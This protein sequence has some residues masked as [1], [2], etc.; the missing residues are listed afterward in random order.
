MLENFMKQLTKDLEIEESLDTGVP[1]VYMFPVDENIGIDISEIPHGFTLACTF[2]EC[3]EENEEE[4][5]THALLANLF[6]QGT[7]QSVLGLDAEAKRLS[8][9]RKV[10]YPI[11]Y[12]EFRDMVED[13]LNAVEFWNEESSA[14]GTKIE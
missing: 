13:F 10:D 14:Y 1:G 9:S 12:R 11:E 6:G 4:F 2:G 8:L 7:D 5:Y 3:P